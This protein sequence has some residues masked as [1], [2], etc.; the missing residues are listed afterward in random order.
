MS[1]KNSSCVYVTSSDIMSTGKQKITNQFIL[2]VSVIVFLSS[3][4]D[5]NISL[6]GKHHVNNVCRSMTM[7]FL[8]LHFQ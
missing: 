7:L 1:M 4:D 6:L 5:T 2:S 3:N 8:Q